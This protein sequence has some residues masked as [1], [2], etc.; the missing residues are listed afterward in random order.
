MNG[1]I[2]GSLTEVRLL[3]WQKSCNAKSHEIPFS[4]HSVVI[5]LE[6]VMT[7]KSRWD[8]GVAWQ[9]HN[10]QTIP[11]KDL[12]P[13]SLGR[14]PGN[15]WPARAR[16]PVLWSPL[17]RSVSLTPNHLQKCPLEPPGVKF[18]RG[19]GTTSG[20]RVTSTRGRFLFGGHT[21]SV[22]VTMLTLCGVWR[23]RVIE[24]RST[25]ALLQPQVSRCV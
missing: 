19:G 15:E 13:D 1:C 12:N 2:Y 9:R 16:A 22:A 17:D 20:C 8:K 14:Y 10:S 5:Q 25:V 4:C 24:G 6:A 18:P 7:D 11:P 21:A 23:K 3:P